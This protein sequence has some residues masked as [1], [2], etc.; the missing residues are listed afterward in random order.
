MGFNWATEGNPIRAAAA[1][2][3]S[4]Q[5][6]EGPAKRFRPANGDEDCRS[7]PAT[8]PDRS[9]PSQASSSRGAHH[10]YDP[11]P[12]CWGQM[13]PCLDDGQELG[14]LREAMG[15][16]GTAIGITPLVQHLVQPPRSLVVSAVLPTLRTR[17]SP[18]PK[19]NVEASS[20]FARS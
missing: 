18:I 9:S 12:D 13:V 2:K 7:N 1:G 16:G 6:D 3:G 20:P 19:L 8:V 15:R 14:V 11:R 4:S 10:G 5:A 17:R